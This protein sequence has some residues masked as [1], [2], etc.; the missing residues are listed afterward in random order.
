M[1]NA[2]FDGLDE[3]LQTVT[4]DWR[5]P[6]RFAESSRPRVD[7]R[8]VWPLGAALDHSRQS[9]NR[10]TLRRREKAADRK[11]GT[12]VLRRPLWYGNS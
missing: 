7:R 11:P 1:S 3:A 4:N 10:T 12:C 9:N 5:S 8:I 6:P 2:C